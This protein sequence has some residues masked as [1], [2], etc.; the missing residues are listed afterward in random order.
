MSF[1]DLRQ[2]LAYLQERGELVTIDD[3]VDR[4]YE[5]AA[6]IRKS[7]DCNGPAFL[8]KNVRGFDMPVVGGIFCSSNK[9]LLALEMTDY[10]QGLDRFIGALQRPV[11][12]R[13]VAT[14]PCKEVRLAGRAVDL[15]R[16]PMPIYSEQ[17]GGAYITMG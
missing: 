3:E 4:R 5:V 15:T 1:A 17:D 9:A 13:R 12:P 2:F 6:Y 7:S 16:L 14:G 10:K 8:F 11:E